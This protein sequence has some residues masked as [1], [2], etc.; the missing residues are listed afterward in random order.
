MSI[1]NE[2]SCDDRNAATSEAVKKGSVKGQKGS[3]KATRLFFLLVL[4]Q[5]RVRK[6]EQTIP[7]S[8]PTTSPACW[9]SEFNMTFDNGKIR[10]EGRKREGKWGAG[11]VGGRKEE[12]GK[13]RLIPETRD[14]INN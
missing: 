4:P 13:T 1:D 2:L 9:D 3:P 6:E 12:F 11:R 14:C 10:K 7:T 8:S 5:K